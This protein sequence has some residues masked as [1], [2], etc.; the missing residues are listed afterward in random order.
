MVVD[1]TCVCCC[2]LLFPN[3]FVVLLVCV[4]L[5]LLF[6]VA[7]LADLCCLVWCW[8]VK[9]VVDGFDFWFNWLV[10]WFWL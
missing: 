5:E 6:A 9:L 10:S 2:D 1:I 4:L 3:L 8:A 7:S